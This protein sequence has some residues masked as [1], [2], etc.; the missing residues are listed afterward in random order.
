MPSLSLRCQCGN[1]R[2][3]VENI[4]PDLGNRVVCY[5]KDCQAFTKA[6]NKQDDALNPYGGTDVVQLPPALIRIEQGQEYIRCL[7]LTEKGLYRWYAGCCNTPIGNSVGPAWP[8]LSVIH[9]FIDKSQD[10][11]SLIGPVSGSVNLKGATDRVPTDI[12]GPN[13]TSKSVL[14]ILKKLL[15][16]KLKGLAT[17][18]PVYRADGQPIVEPEILNSQQEHKPS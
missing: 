3:Q 17:P 5:C 6:L 11:D 2:G 1:I 18:S 7:R 10:V 9:S 14:A 12:I 16:W 8:L 13:S 4:N 15:V